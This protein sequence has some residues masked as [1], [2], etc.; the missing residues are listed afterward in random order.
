METKNKYK[1]TKLNFDG[2]EA[3]KLS[4]A[5]GGNKTGSNG[6]WDSLFSK[7][8]GTFMAG[9]GQGIASIFGR[10]QQQTNNNYQYPES[11]SPGFGSIFLYGGGA[12]VV[13]LLIVLF[14]KK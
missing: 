1:N 6:F 8:G 2:S 5:T 7:G 11:N 10:G 14:M 12:I 13:I 3:G 9:L 4:S